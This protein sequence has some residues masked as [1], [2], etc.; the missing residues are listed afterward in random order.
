MIIDFANLLRKNLQHKNTIFTTV[1]EEKVFL[2][3]YIRL[4]NNH[5]F[6]RYRILMTIDE[7]I[8]EAKIPKMLDEFPLHIFIAITRKN[9]HI[10][11]NVKN[12]LY[13]KNTSFDK[14]KM[15]IG[16]DNITNRLKVLYGNDFKFEISNL[17]GFFNCLIEVPHKR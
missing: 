16:T 11:I 4:L 6:D 2:K 10:Q 12:R 14:I 17:D 7:D 9:Q 5:Q 3:E 8:E 1:A 15:G 13:K